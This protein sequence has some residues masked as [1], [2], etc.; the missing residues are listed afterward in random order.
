[1]LTDLFSSRNVNLPHKTM[2]FPMQVKSAIIHAAY[3]NVGF[4]KRSA[5]EIPGGI[6]K[7]RKIVGNRKATNKPSVFGRQ[8]DTLSFGSIEQ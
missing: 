8:T 2:E 3:L 7:A 1:M 5:L 4:I 6:E